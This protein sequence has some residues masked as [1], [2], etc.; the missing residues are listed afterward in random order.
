MEIG[1]VETFPVPVEVWSILNPI[2]V[3]AAVWPVM[4]D[5]EWFVRDFWVELLAYIL[6]TD[7][8]AEF[9]DLNYL[10]IDLPHEYKLSG[11]WWE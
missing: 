2:L 7:L 1:P 9:L 11:D 10:L 4:T 6:L 8:D 5:L 3:D